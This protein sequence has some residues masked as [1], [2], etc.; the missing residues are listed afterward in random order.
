METRDEHLAALAALN[1]P[2]RRRTYRYVAAQGS[3]VNRDDVATALE[4]PRS[5]VAF[6]LDKLAQTG[7]LKVEYRRPVGRGGPGAGRPTKLYKKSGREI[8]LSVPQRSYD[9]AA[10]LLAQAVEVSVKLQQPATEAA[11]KVAREYGKS[12]T[13]PTEH[14]RDSKP[15]SRRRPISRLTEILAEQGYEPRTDGRTTT[16]TN[17]P[18]GG[19]AKGHRDL[20]CG[21]NLEL[22]KGIAEGVGLGETAVQLRPSSDRCCVAISPA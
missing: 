13:S 5:V 10:Q 16:L 12:L 14:S 22:V 11:R 2:L 4:V 17:C 19:L 20:V 7:L 6:H 18:F 8:S 1:E 21:M 9:L 15:H 3:P